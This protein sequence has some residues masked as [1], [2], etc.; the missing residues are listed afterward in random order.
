MGGSS[1]IV[2]RINCFALNQIW[3]DEIIHNRL[4]AAAV[5]M[6]PAYHAKV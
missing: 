1:V 4:T 5:Y 2:A 6:E 3:Y